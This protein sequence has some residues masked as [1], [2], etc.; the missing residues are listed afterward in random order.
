M[1][2]LPF[3]ILLLLLAPA[4][5]QAAT[6]S[7]ADGAVTYTAAPGETNRVT[8]TSATEVRDSTATLTAGTGCTLAAPGRVTC[9]AATRFA[10][11]LGDGDDTLTTSLS[12]PVTVSDGAGRDTVTGG[13]GAD[14]FLA[15]AGN[16]VYNGGTGT[17]R[18]DFSARTRRRRRRPRRRQ[19]RGRHLHAR[20]RT[21][22]AAP[23]TT[24]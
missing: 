2:A 6:V 23:A 11:D 12:V 21:S 5:A 15:G 4:S 16:D 1:R 18:I 14:V 17:D 13:T 9:A 22:P 3:L 20:S 19:R 10:I 7:F 8:L 24:T